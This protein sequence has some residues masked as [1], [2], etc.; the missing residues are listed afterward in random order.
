MKCLSLLS[1]VG[2]MLPA[3]SYAGLP[4]T[5]TTTLPLPVDR[6]MEQ[7]DKQAIDFVVSMPVYQDQQDSSQYY[8]VPK[9]K[10][11]TNADGVSATFLKNDVAVSSSSVITDLSVKV[12]SLTSEEYFNAV[13]IVSNLEKIIID[14]VARNPSDP[15]IQ[16]Y[17]NY[18][19]KALEKKKEIEAKANSF[20]QSIPKGVLTS[21][22]NNIATIFGAAGIHF[23][24]YENEIVTARHNRLNRNLA[25]LNSSNGGLITGNIYGGFTDGE[26][27]KIKTYK[28]KYAPNLK[29]SV[30]PLTSLS[31]ESLTELQYDS[32][33]VKSQRAGI[34]I[35]SSLKGGGTLSGATFNFDLTTN[36]AVSFARNLS[37]FIPP[38]SIKGVL[39][40]QVGSYKATLDCDFGPGLII[41]DRSV[42]NKQVAVFND[43]TISNMIMS[44]PQSQSFCRVTIHSGDTKAAYYAAVQALET[45]VSKLLAQK[46]NLSPVDKSQY[47]Q[48]IQQQQGQIIDRTQQNNGH[49]NVFQAYQQSGWAQSAVSAL[50]SRP[51]YYWQ[52]NAQEMTM[53]NGLKI[54]KEL[55]F[56]TASSMSVSIPTNICLVWNVHVKAYRACNEGEQAK[57]IPLT[58]ATQSA[59]QSQSCSDTQD[60]IQCGNNRNTNA[61]TSPEG[62]ILPE[63]L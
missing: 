40:Q 6:T 46:S 29:I 45:E 9:L 62:N 21:I 23:P 13:K 42:I 53:L 47:W 11:S 28:S 7:N 24:I 51:N 56:E 48:Q 12:S 49:Q 20:E 25:D 55:S 1:V 44:G 34:P 41:K 8:Y 52:I 31:F 35:F 18:L 60:A 33:G 54:H 14:T 19:N 27:L 63:N 36:G 2:L 61:P 26:I 39:H 30:I 32:Y 3:I 38:L 58:D 4:N 50:A 22:Y 37:P 43:N 15:N 17:Q 59:K 57:A 5:Q 16:I 10:A